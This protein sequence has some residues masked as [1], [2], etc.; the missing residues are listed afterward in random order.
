MT[1]PDYGGSPQLDEFNAV[2]D[3][4]LEASDKLGKAERMVSR[5][6]E[7][8]GALEAQAYDAW[9]KDWM[10]DFPAVKDW[11][12]LISEIKETKN[13]L[14]TG[15]VCCS[16]REPAGKTIDIIDKGKMVFADD[17]S[18]LNAP[19]EKPSYVIEAEKEEKEAWSEFMEA[20]RWDFD[21]G[22]LYS[23]RSLTAYRKWLVALNAKEEAYLKWN[24]ENKE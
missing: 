23:D 10:L 24:S 15:G 14:T 1:H 8:G 4:L 6:L 19:Q 5:L 21:M 17:M 18:A 13:K 3:D 9:S 22:N 2:M 12:L 11:E 20:S 7:V 16:E